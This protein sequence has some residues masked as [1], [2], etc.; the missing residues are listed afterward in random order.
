MII[1]PL[2]CAVQENVYTAA[3]GS[4]QS[5]STYNST[6]GQ[7]TTNLTGAPAGTQIIVGIKYTPSDLKGQAV[8]RVC[9]PTETYTFSDSGGGS[10]SLA[11]VPKN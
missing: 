2:A 8:T 1:C 3:C 9:H 4:V 6:T 7:I 10:D 5:S 11:L